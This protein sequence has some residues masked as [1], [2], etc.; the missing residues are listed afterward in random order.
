MNVCVRCSWCSVVYDVY[1][2]L[3]DWLLIIMGNQELSR[4]VA[5]KT[6]KNG[7]ETGFSWEFVWSVTK[8]EP[9]E[10]MT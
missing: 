10:N 4:S 6:I 1:R 8:R 5:M 3:S 9:R 7:T 2:E